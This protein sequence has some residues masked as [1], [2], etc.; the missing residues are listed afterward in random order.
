MRFA[1]RRSYAVLDF[2]GRL[3]HARVTSMAFAKNANRDLFGILLSLHRGL[4][5]PNIK[6]PWPLARVA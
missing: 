5:P 6:V 3:L 4:A 2:E 1:A